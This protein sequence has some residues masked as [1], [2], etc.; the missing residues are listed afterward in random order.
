MCFLTASKLFATQKLP[1]ESYFGLMIHFKWICLT[2]L[3]EWWTKA[4]LCTRSSVSWDRRSSL[5][6]D[7]SHSQPCVS[8]S[9]GFFQ[10]FG[11][12]CVSA[13]G[14]SLRTFIDQHSVNIQGGR[15]SESGTPPLHSPSPSLFLWTLTAML[16]L[17]P[18]VSSLLKETQVL[19]GLHP[20]TLPWKPF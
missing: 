12:V 3:E 20:R 17:T 10:S 9:Y 15:S 11:M 6:W 8:V 14:N 18:V 2:F 19:P 7:G 5:W 16:S 13:S 1:S 4:L